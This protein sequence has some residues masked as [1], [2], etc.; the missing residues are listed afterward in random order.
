MAGS[1]SCLNAAVPA[2]LDCL[3]ITHFPHV[4]PGVYCTE[5]GINTT[6]AAVAWLAGLLYGDRQ[7]R[8]SARDY[9]RLG[10][11][12]AAV[13]AGANGV[14]ALPVL[15]DGDRRDSTIR[16][17][18]VGLSARHTRGV[19]ARAMLEAV[20][21][22]IREQLETL[23]RF[24]PVTELRVSGGSARIEGWSQIK[25]DVI[26]VPVETIPVD[27]ASRGA[28]MLA[29]LGVGV[30]R[31]V[32]DAIERCVNRGPMKAPDDTSHDAY[33]PTYDRYRE[34]AASRVVRTD[35][36]A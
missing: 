33:G 27:A 11:E 26:G 16:A 18:F 25:A 28:A 17:A 19:I 23:R 20:A 30:Y 29:G 4:V 31:S 6:G 22:A 5:T 34:L 32:D 1:S 2:P 24:T 36:Y 10:V 14:V 8:V 13:P 12:A 7:G 9:A 21:F 35:S 3:D 15:G